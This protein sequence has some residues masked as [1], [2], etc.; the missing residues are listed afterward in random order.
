MKQDQIGDFMEDY[1]WAMQKGNSTFFTGK[2]IRK[3]ILRHRTRLV[4]SG[5]LLTYGE[6]CK[7][8]VGPRFGC[9]VLAIVKA[10]GLS[11]MEQEGSA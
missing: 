2:S 10:E 5:Q 8:M 3:L 9:E 4:E 11:A 7:Y 1:L 6:P